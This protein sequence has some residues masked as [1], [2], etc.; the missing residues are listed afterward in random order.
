M[1]DKKDY[2]EVLGVSKDASEK[3]I[4]AAYRKLA[5]KHHPDRSDD[6][7][8]EERFKE[9]SEAYAVLSDS[10]K[11]QKYDQFGHAGI[12][13]Q[14]SQEDLFRG[15][16]F[17]DLLRGFGMGGESIFDMFF[18]GGGGRRGPARGRDLR[19]DIDLTLEQAARGLE[20]TI[21]VPRTESCPKC[22]GSGAKPGT[23]PVTC[24]NCRGSGQVTR[25]QNTPFGQMV[26]STTC[27][28]C[29]GRGEIITSP[30][31]DC[32]GSGRVRKS[33]KINIKVPAGVEDGQH[34][35][36]RGQGDSAGPKGVS[37]DLYV[38]INILPHRIFQRMDSDLIMES[39]ISFTQAA[40]G[41]DLEVPT[42]NGR[43]R[44]KVPAG[45]Q[46]GTVFRLRGK[47]MP[48]LH[49]TGS[50][51]LHVRV[52]INTPSAL[53]ARQKQLLEELAEEFGEQKRPAGEREKEKEK[54]LIDKI[55]DEVKSAV[56]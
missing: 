15:V 28:T 17:E 44:I 7:G 47:G 30:C 13:S 16:N 49:G 29:G 21:E 18:G 19:Y 11:R 53:T 51:D 43:A 56:Q 26:T 3:D 50:G 6:P 27:P 45:T 55:V 22:Q 2:Y 34:L 37:G 54:S 46:T 1:P 25:A 12:N 8:A 5:M 33:R 14:Y 20:T 41:A 48:R 4:K 24:S 36:L 42:L 32:S 23:T 31:E 40:L 9:L 52:R 39:P 38:V 10:D 35:K